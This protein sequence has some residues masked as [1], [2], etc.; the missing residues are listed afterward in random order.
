MVGVFLFP[1]FRD[2]LVL[3]LSVFSVIFTVVF[4]F[5]SPVWTAFVFVFFFAARFRLLSAK[6]DFFLDVTIS[7][8]LDEFDVKTAFFFR[9]LFV[10]LVDFFFFSGTFLEVDFPA[11]FVF[12]SAFFA[13]E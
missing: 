9:V 8:F 1:V 5:P 7:S 10:A 4:F 6:V 11:L 12:D 2:L 3:D 13:I